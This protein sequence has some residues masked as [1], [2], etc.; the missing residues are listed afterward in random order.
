MAKL[1]LELCKDD[2]HVRDFSVRE[3]ISE[4]F[5]MSVVALSSNHDVDLESVVGR[6]AGLIIPGSLGVFGWTGVCAHM[7]QLELETSDAGRS[8]YFLRIVPS[9]WLLT[10]R[11]SYRIFQH[12][13]TKDIV[14]KVLDE[15]RVQVQFE[16]IDPPPKLEY[17]VQYGETD[18]AF[19]SRLLEEAGISY[20]FERHVVGDKTSDAGGTF[21][22]NTRLVCCDN[23]DFNATMGE[24]PHRGE[25]NESHRK[26]SFIT[27]VGVG[28]RTR[29]G[30]LTY[31][32][33]NFRTPSFDFHKSS[34]IKLNAKEKI[35]EPYEHFQYF[36]G[37]S[38]VDVDDRGDRKAKDRTPVA[39]EKSLARHEEKILAARAQRAAEARRHEKRHVRFESNDPNIAPGQVFSIGGHARASVGLGPGN[40][41]LV[42]ESNVEGSLDGWRL[43]AQ[44][45]FADTRYRPEVR[46]PRPR[47]EGPQTA[48]VVGPQN[49]EIHA[50]EFGRVKVRFH[51]DRE[52]DFDEN[53]TCW[54][55]VSQTWAGS[56]FGSMHI[57]RI[58][59]EVIVDFFEGNPDQPVVIGRLFN[60]TAT[61][62]RE[63]PKHKTQSIWRSATS[64][65]REKAFHEIM[66]DDEAGKELIFIQS[67]RDLLKLVKGKETERTGENRTVI[68]GDGRVAGVA[69]ADTTQVGKQ[70]LIKMVAVK[71]L[72]IHEMGEPETTPKDTWIEMVDGRISLTTGDATVVLDGPN[73]GI[74]AKGALRFTA[75]GRLIM[76]GGPYVYL[77]D[78]YASINK[79]KA[80][81]K[82]KDLVPKPDRM[83]GSVEKLFWTKPVTTALSRKEIT[84]SVTTTDSLRKL[85]ETPGTRPEQIAARRKVAEDFYREEGWKLIGGKRVRKLTPDEIRSQI[86]C[87]DLNGPVVAGPPPDWPSDA[88][89]EQWQAPG[90]SQG[91]F[92]AEHGVMP[93][94]IGI[95]MQGTPRDAKGKFV[96]GPDGKYIVQN[97]TT[98]KHTPT[99]GK[100]GKPPPFLRSIAAPANDFWS[101]PDNQIQYAPGGGV[102]Y[103]SSRPDQMVKL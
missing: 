7:E 100:D 19:V 34:E 86:K 62:P 51:W 32:D 49:K 1:E 40:K 90:G 89:M 102:Q 61:V 29:P 69:E 3:R 76:K 99:V 14:R 60:A 57:P 15:Y 28:H 53:S 75:D 77:N 84:V 71:N 48:I 37:A 35:E 4:P 2:F 5:E 13:D 78:S 101:L 36:H 44:A 56:R 65:R 85:A 10:Q 42:I 8:T 79:K 31:A 33:Y 72:R 38:L 30:K 83:I 52:G 24:I 11:R 59:Q 21:S 12:M 22:V 26:T 17:R 95:G 39:D 25:P 81:G 16:L 46:T 74:H 68:V 67:Q 103:Y 6:G 66:F 63:L 58:G 91:T 55:R 94:A 87:I 88:P 96:K 92:Y 80:D 73:I 82:V 45:V 20:Y 18:Y 43:Q 64:P 41:L 98:T 27:K 50:D 97:K 23:P 9:L 54:L 70:R 47:V 93:D